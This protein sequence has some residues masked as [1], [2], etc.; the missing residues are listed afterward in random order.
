MGL[1]T[2]GGKTG[3]VF[4]STSVVEAIMSIGIRRDVGECRSLSLAGKRHVE[5]SA[6]SHY[7]TCCFIERHRAPRLTHRIP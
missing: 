7:V 5:T 2:R 1:G 6:S 3:L 4:Y